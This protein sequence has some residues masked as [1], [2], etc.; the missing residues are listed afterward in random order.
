MRIKHYCITCKDHVDIMSREK[1]PDAGTLIT[2]LSCGHNKSQSLK[3]D[4]DFLDITSIDNKKPYPY[5]LEG[6]SFSFNS[7]GR[8]L[9]LDEMGLGKTVQAA[10]FIKKLGRRYLWICKSGLKLQTLREITRWCGDEYTTQ[11]LERENDSILPVTGFIM[12]MDMVRKI[13]DIP[14]FVKRLGVRNGVLILDEVQH[15]KNSGSKRTQAI[16]D[17]SRQVN[18]IIGL[19]G[20]PIK[21]HAGEYYPILH[22]IR[23]DLFPTAT[24]FDACWVQSY[25][26]GYQLKKQGLK[27]FQTFQ[28]FTKDFI[29]RR[30]RAE[31]L[32]DLPSISR[33]NMFCELGSAVEDAYKETLKQFQDYYLYG[34]AGVSAIEKSAGILAFLSKMRHLTGIAKILPVCDYLEDFISE[35][36]R[37]IVVFLH[38]KDVAK[39]LLA[40][41]E[42]A[43]LSPL[44]L[45]DDPNKRQAVIDEFRDDNTKRIL[46]ASTLASGEGL[47]L[48][49]C[50]DCII[51]ELQWTP[52]N[53][54]QAEAR[55]PRPG[56][57]ADKI[58]AKY[59]I[60][61]G[62]VDEFLTDLREK[63][64]SYV[65]N[66]LDGTNYSWD[67]SSVIKELAEVLATQG[68]KK[69][70]W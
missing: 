26:D 38:H 52:V 2:Q 25:W 4:T 53:E 12:S 32:P 5:Q 22:M 13:K 49:F 43:G 6:A 50:S 3:K 58:T 17:L 56:Q 21:N 30:T 62:T 31:V 33:E 20:T 34:S 23:P 28:A 8:A 14:E 63:K 29:I 51:M 18:H 40:K 37:K 24:N 66:S 1:V 42:Q 61:V 45:P 35:T 59:F 68:G 16:S 46:I 9:I 47:N 54:E 55:F 19:S 48:Q 65:S 36:D 27:D 70:S 11:I 7:G 39:T 41:L 10:M 67:E 15:L 69:W 64:R 60:A 57:K 44:I